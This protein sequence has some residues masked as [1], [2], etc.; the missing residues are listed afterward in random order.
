M[1]IAVRELNPQ[2]EGDRSTENHSE[3]IPDLYWS[4]DREG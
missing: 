3:S 1:L 2:D 4:S